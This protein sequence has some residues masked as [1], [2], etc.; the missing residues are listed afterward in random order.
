M[1]TAKTRTATAAA[2]PPKT[3]SLGDLPEWDLADLYPG[4]DAPELKRDLDKAASDAA[5]F[6]SRWKGTLGAEAGKGAEGGLGA[7][8]AEYEALEELIGRIVSYASLV[9]AGDT[10]D[11]KRGKLYGDIQEKMT[12]ASTHLLFFALEL[13]KV[14]D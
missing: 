9:Y 1:T 8:L 11:P 10:T 14:D 4:M 12:D 7:C 3:A 13:N 5:A 6:E 2:R